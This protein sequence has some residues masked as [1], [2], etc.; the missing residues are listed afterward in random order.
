MSGR[1][2]IIVANAVVNPNGP[3]PRDYTVARRLKMRY[4]AVLPVFFTVALAAAALAAQDPHQHPQPGTHP[5]GGA[6]HHPE[7]AKKTNPV[8]ADATSIAAGQKL[9]A[10]DCAGC[11]GDTGKG[12]GSMADELNPKPADLTDADWKHGS[13]DGELFLV[14]S[15]GAKNTGM[16]A[17]KSKMTAHQI[18]D[19]VN[20]VRTLGP[21]PAKSH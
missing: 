18:W 9:Y 12:D 19:V 20:Y 13:S 7:A 2:P 6:H 11:H 5:A 21:K 4:A 1:F 10:K 15:D 14:V 8:K 16:K 3:K 17:F